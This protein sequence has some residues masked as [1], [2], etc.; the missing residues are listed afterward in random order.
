MIGAAPGTT[1]FLNFFPSHGVYNMRQP[2]G[3]QF[4]QKFYNVPTMNFKLLIA[5]LPFL[6]APIGVYADSTQSTD[7]A[8]QATEQQ[9]ASEVSLIGLNDPDIDSAED[10]EPDC[11]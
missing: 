10:E 1:N 4:D 2:D 8:H 7:Q 6:L 11:E 5:I 3:C 9:A